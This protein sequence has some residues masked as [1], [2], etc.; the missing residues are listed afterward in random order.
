M[1]LIRWRMGIEVRND[2]IRD[3]DEIVSAH[4]V[5]NRGLVQRKRAVEDGMTRYA[6]DAAHVEREMNLE[7]VMI[8]EVSAAASSSVL[9]RSVSE[10]LEK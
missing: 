9:R 2:S 7:H 8:Y 10:Q 5:L 3:L 4:R 6:S 1:G